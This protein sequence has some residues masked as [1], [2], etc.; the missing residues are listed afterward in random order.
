MLDRVSAL[1][2]TFEVDSPRGVGTTVRAAIPC[3]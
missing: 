3:E 1:G 2:E